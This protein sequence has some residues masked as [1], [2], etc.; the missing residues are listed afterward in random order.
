MEFYHKIRTLCR[1][2]VTPITIMLI[3]HNYTRST[4]NLNVPAIA[5]VIST[6]FSFVGLIYFCSLIPDVIRYR[7]I[8]Q[9]L[10]D[11][12]KKVS[13]FNATLLSLKKEE[14]DLH[15]LVSLGS[16]A[17]IMEKVDA[18][19]MGAFDINQVQQQIEY[20]LQ[21]VG[22]I[23]DYLRT[24]KDL[25]LA[26]PR[27]L[28][29]AGPVTSSYGSRINP[30]NG[31]SEF[32]H[33]LDISASAGTP[34]TTTADGVVSFAGWNGGG[35]KL[36]VIA[37]GQ[38]FFTYYAHN[39]KIIVEVGQRVKRGE[40]ISYTGSTGSA[41]GNHSHYEVWREGKARNPMNYMEE[42]S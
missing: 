33:G 35:G 22:A 41:T 19:G 8:E 34:V 16:K 40:T 37:H 38:G 24:Q 5:I 10:V 25:Y 15:A 21:T 36:V 9:Q 32:H 20:S 3:P 17:K 23:K 6:I 2:A 28:P 18:S 42:K 30:I 14:K 4:L 12:S 26:T 29:V 31:R 39:S 27:G 13:D 7:G 1:K 11:Y